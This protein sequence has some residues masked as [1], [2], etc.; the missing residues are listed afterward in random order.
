ML[1]SEFSTAFEPCIEKSGT[2]LDDF[3]TLEGEVLVAFGLIVG[4]DG[5]QGTVESLGKALEVFRLAA[6]LHK[7][8]VTA[9]SVNI[10]KY[11]SGGVFLHLGI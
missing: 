7:P 1:T 3:K 4:I 9:M 6:E 2:G 10:H 8:L 5:L 11:R